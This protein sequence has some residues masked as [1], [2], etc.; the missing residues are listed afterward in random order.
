MRFCR[1]SLLSNQSTLGY[2]QYL[3]PSGLVDI[4]LPVTRFDNLC[5]DSEYF[6]GGNILNGKKPL[7]SGKY[8]VKRDGV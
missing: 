7:V 8:L 3:V 1:L 2:V 5:L 4:F 6:I